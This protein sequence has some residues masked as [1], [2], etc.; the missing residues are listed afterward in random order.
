MNERPN[1]RATSLVI[2]IHGMDRTHNLKPVAEILAQ[3]EAELARAAAAAI[4]QQ[5]DETI[6]ICSEQ[7]TSGMYEKLAELGDS[8]GVKRAK[9]EVRLLM[10]TAMHYADRHYEDIARVLSL[11]LDSPPEV[12][13]DAYFTLAVV[14]LSFGQAAEAREAMESALRTIGELRAAGWKDV[15]AELP[16]QEREAKEFL[17]ELEKGS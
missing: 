16:R 11:A 2:V 12:R 4:E 17:A 10:A 6:E 5:Y 9:A 8:D 7:L 3:H 15:G 1:A 13:K 14:H